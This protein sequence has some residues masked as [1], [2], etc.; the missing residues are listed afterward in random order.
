MIYEAYAVFIRGG[1][2]SRE[3][4]D[5]SIFLGVQSNIRKLATSSRVLTARAKY[6]GTEGA[7]GSGA[8]HG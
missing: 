7:L 1:I 8:G 3:T 4:L 5:N 2:G 6:A